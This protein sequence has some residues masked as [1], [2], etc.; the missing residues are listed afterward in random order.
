MTSQRICTIS[1]CGKRVNAKGFCHTHYWRFRRYGDPMV[2]TIRPRGS[3]SFTRT[4]HVR[5]TSN[6]VARMAHV[7]IAEKAFGK[8]LPRGVVVHHINEDPADNRNG[9]LLICTLSYH[10][11][12]HRRMRALA[13][14]GNANWRKCCR[15]KQYSNP[16]EMIVMHGHF[17]HRHCTT[18]KA[19]GGTIYIQFNGKR[20]SMLAWA[21]ELH[22]SPRTIAKRHRRGMPPEE[23]LRQTGAN[24]YPRT[25]TR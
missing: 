9:N 14:C 5:I 1:G 2:T 16:D 8:P 17:H 10:T 21:H 15:C 11:M 23:I 12:I 13:E 3:G 19:R 25:A 22:I 20:K 18:G 7:I 4:G 6:R 24:P